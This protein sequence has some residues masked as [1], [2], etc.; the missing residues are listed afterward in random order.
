MKIRADLGLRHLVFIVVLASFIAG[1]I[2]LQAELDPTKSYHLLQQIAHGV[3][4]TGLWGDSFGRL[5]SLDVR[6]NDGSVV[7]NGD[8]IVDEANLAYEALYLQGGGAGGATYTVTECRCSEG[9]SRCPDDKE[10]PPQC[11]TG[12]TPLYGRVEGYML[13]DTQHSSFS[14]PFCGMNTR[15]LHSTRVQRLSCGMPCTDP[16]LGQADPCPITNDPSFF[17]KLLRCQICVK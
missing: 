10:G 15:N 14:I 17:D 5:N 4:G 8:G 7:P 2:Q 11:K 12:W 1:I 6:N 13:V 3:D 9:D 16:A